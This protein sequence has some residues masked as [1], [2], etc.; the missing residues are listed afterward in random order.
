MIKNTKAYEK[1]LITTSQ[2][3]FIQ[4][5]KLEGR[6]V[7]ITGASGMIGSYLV[8]LLTT[9]NKMC[10]GGIT[11]HALSRSI[12]KLED[13]FGRDNAGVNMIAQD[14]CSPIDDSLEVDYIIHAAS[15]THPLEYA[16]R[17]VDT[18]TTNIIGLRNLFEYAKKHK[19]CR[20]VVL[21]S[22]EVYG[23]NRG[24]TDLFD[25]KYCGYLDCNT[26]RA[27][28]PESKRLSETMA[29]A[30]KSQYGVDSVIIRLSRVYGPG[31]ETDDS[32]AMTQFINKAASGEDIILK[33][34]GSQLYSYTYVADAA[35]GILKVM[36]DGES[37]QA[38]N[39]ADPSSNRT[40]KE[41]A[42][43]LAASV[44]RKV[45]YDL[46]DEAEKKG[47]STATK[48]L[49][50]GNKIKELGWTPSFDMESG[51]AQTLYLMNKKN[52]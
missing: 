20:V 40:L 29:Q 11:V 23:E 44:G 21:S 16:N 28:Y 38:Y 22:V 14:I 5:D 49:L 19:G 35:S 34:D 37:G 47:Y 2:E 45:V 8:D 25:E 13:R 4:W 27:G 24:D 48:A 32:K 31:V 3:P 6:S 7:L 30:Y 15:N 52:Q 41:I 26:L 51:L 43:Y 42:E 33:S 39:V 12:S 10:D 17:P 18:I 1:E 9:H 46:P 50:D 36:T